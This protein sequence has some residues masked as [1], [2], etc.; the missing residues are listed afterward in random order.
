M[1]SETGS[2]KGNDVIGKRVKVG[3]LVSRRETKRRRRGKKRMRIEAEEKDAK[4]LGKGKK[5]Q[6]EGKSKRIG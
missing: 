4:D 5:D 6:A 2:E 1:P 3:W